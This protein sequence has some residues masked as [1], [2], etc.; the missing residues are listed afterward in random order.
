MLMGREFETSEAS[1]F[2]YTGVMSADFQ[3]EGHEPMSRLA[4]YKSLDTYKISPNVSTI[5]QR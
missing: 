5:V 2:L 4:I 1:P 3:S